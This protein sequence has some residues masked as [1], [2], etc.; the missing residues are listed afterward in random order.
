M[1]IHMPVCVLVEVRVLD[2][3]LYHPS[4]YL[5]GMGCLTEPEAHLFG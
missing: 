5:F 1:Y 3:F 2:T 4:S